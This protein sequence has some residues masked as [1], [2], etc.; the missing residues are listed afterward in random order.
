MNYENKYTID[1]QEYIYDSA[2][3]KLETTGEVKQRIRARRIKENKAKEITFSL[4]GNSLIVLGLSLLLISNNAKVYNKQREVQLL[5][6]SIKQEKANYESNR[7]KLLQ[8]S[9]ISSISDGTKRVKMKL[10]NKEDIIN[11][12]ITK[13]YFENIR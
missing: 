13:D 9:S 10:P 2:A 7:V 4:I 5:T 12:E 6:A 8:Y 1:R 11:V 3:R